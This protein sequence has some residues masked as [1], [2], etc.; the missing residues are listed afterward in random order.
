MTLLIVFFL[1]T[2][3]QEELDRSIT[4]NFNE[5]WRPHKRKIAASKTS[6]YPLI[7]L[8]HVPLGFISSWLI[9]EPLAMLAVFQNLACYSRFW[10]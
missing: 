5:S 9:Y 8:N 2:L 1:V 6:T 3:T 7:Q 10:L 4:M